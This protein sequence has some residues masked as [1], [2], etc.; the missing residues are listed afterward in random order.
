M[1]ALHATHKRGARYARA[2]LFTGSASRT[3]TFELS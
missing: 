3:P 1:S 2:E